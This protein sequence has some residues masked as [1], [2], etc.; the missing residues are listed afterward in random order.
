MMAT[1]NNVLQFLL[2]LLVLGVRT[3]W[4]TAKWAAD[5]D[6]IRA[7]LSRTKAIIVR[8]FSDRWSEGRP[9]Y[10]SNPAEEGIVLSW[11]PIKIIGEEIFQAG[12]VVYAKVADVAVKAL[13]LTWLLVPLEF[14]V[15]L[16][17][18]LWRR[19][20]C[21]EVGLRAHRVLYF[22][23]F[24]FVSASTFGRVWRVMLGVVPLWRV[25]LG[26]EAEMPIR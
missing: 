25:M 18:V 20:P 11:H 15:S 7:G 23:W 5:L 24:A 4:D 1:T 10:H 19:L 16:W 8:L 9:L 17:F 14:L 2:D 12:C 21:L 26:K 13:T 22:F 6:T 3:A